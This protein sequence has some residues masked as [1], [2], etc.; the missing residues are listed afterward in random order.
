MEQLKGYL[1]VASLALLMVGMMD[2]Q[3]GE[4]E[5]DGKV[6]QKGSETAKKMVSKKGNSME[7]YLDR[8]MAVH[9]VG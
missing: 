5:A 7:Y 8:V 4:S 9:L 3:L 1:M 6:V 2:C